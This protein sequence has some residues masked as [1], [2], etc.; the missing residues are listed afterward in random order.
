MLNPYTMLEGHFQYSEIK[1]KEVTNGTS[2][3]L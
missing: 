3:N 1:N 2:K